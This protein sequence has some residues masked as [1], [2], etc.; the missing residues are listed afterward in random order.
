MVQS[1]LLEV[2]VAIYSF[3]PDVSIYI[4]PTLPGVVPGAP[5]PV[6][7]TGVV[8]ADKLSFKVKVL[9]VVPPAIVNPVDWE[10]R[11]RALIVPSTRRLLSPAVPVPPTCKPPSMVRSVVDRTILGVNAELNVPAVRP[12]LTYQF[13][14]DALFSNIEAVVPYGVILYPLL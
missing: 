10:V 4:F 2:P 5:D 1:E 13:Q 7:I 14:D 3:L 8:D 6:L 9:E 12:E 11:V